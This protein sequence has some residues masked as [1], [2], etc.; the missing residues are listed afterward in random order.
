VEAI[1]SYYYSSMG[2]EMQRK[3]RKMSRPHNIELIGE[4]FSK[5]PKNE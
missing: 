5:I 4:E 2:K 3:H 1:I